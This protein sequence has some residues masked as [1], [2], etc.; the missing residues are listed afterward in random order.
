[1]L[2]QVLDGVVTLLI[3]FGLVLLVTIKQWPEWIR[4]VRS[5]YWPTIPG[6][7]ENG[8]VSTFRSRGRYLDRSIE[9]ATATIGYSY[10]LSGIYYSGYHIETFDD[11]QKAWT[12]VDALRGQRVQVSYNPRKPEASVLRKQPLLLNAV[13]RF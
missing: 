3:L 10:R 11:E 2:H 9:S 7:I 1:M 13:S 8:E 5:A 6:V 4:R 12:Y